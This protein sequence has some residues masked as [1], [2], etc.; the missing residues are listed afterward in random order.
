MPTPAMQRL[1]SAVLIQG[2]AAL[3][4]VQH[5]LALGARERQHRDALPPSPGVRHLLALLA[6]AVAEHETTV[7][8]PRHDGV[9]AGG[10]PGDSTVGKV[11]EITSDQVAALLGVGRRQAQ[12]LA[13]SIGS[14]KVPGG[15]LVFDR[16]AVL[17]YAAQRREDHDPHGR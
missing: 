11:D 7:S 1:G 17:A 3:L 15:A 13:G 8:P 5:L 2:P 12:R 16:C 6:E 9:V 4:E 10:G 14:R